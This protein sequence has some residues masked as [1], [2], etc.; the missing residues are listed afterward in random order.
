M[1]EKTVDWNEYVDSLV[2]RPPQEYG[3]GL[4]PHVPRAATAPTPEP[5][6][7]PAGTTVVKIERDGL[8]AVVSKTTSEGPPHP[9]SG[10]PLAVGAGVMG[11]LLL[12]LVLRQLSHRFA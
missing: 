1:S 2:E 5:T 10:V 9:G 6:P 3:Y 12:V 7:L 8:G 4:G 11:L